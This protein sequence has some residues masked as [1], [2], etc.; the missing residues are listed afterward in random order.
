MVEYGSEKGNLRGNQ[1]PEPWGKDNTIELVPIPP[2][3]KEP[4]IRYQSYPYKREIVK[5]WQNQGAW[6][7]N[8]R[9]TC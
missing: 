4:K 9:I 7:D 1:N 6:E 3:S 5:R 2:N 8:Q